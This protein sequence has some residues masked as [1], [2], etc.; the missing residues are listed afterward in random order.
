MPLQIISLQHTVPLTQHTI[1][2]RVH[3]LRT[4]TKKINSI[5]QTENTISFSIIKIN[6][7]YFCRIQYNT[8]LHSIAQEH[9]TWLQSII[10]AN[11][12]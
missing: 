2:S 4:E 3:K 6:I 7:A 9:A 10:S 5:K 8:A 1:L 12:M 11:N